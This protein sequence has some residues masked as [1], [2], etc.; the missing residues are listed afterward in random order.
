V[1]EL[2]DFRKLMLQPGEQQVV[3][4]TID[5]AK[6]S[7]YNAQLKRVAEPGAFKVQ[8]GLDSQAVKEGSFELR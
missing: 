6:L 8:I 2:K 4:F 3:R 1:K 7:F 5:E